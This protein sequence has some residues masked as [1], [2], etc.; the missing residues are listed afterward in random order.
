[1][2]RPQRLIS[3]LF[4]LGLSSSISLFAATHEITKWRNNRAGAV[5]VTFDDGY[6]SQPTIGKDLLSTRNLKGTFFLITDWLNWSE[7]TWELWQSVAA[8]GHEIGSHSVSHPYL[9]GLPELQLRQELS[10]SQ[11]VINLHIP[12]QFCLSFAYPY[13][14]SNDLVRAVTS[15]YY[16]A[17]RDVGGW[18]EGLNFYPGGRYSSINFYD[19][20][21]ITLDGRTLGQI[22]N[23][24]GSTIQ[25]NAWFVCIIHDLNNSE[26]IQLLSQF[27]DGLLVKDV[28]VDSFGTIVRYMRERLSSTFAVLSENDSEITLSLSHS[29]DN[30]IYN[31]PLTIRSAVPYS[32]SEVLITQGSSEYIVE[33]KIENGEQVVYY[34]AIPNGGMISLLPKNLSSSPRIS[35][36]PSSLSASTIV[37]SNAPTQTFSVWN[38][39]GG[40]L[41]YSISV[42][43]SW[44][45]C[46]PVSGTSTGEQDAITVNYSTASLSLGTYS[47]T[48]TISDPAAG[49][50]PQAI[51]VALTVVSI[52]QA[53][54]EL[55]FEEGSGT[56]AY[57]TS[58][59]NNNGT[60]YGG[61]VYTTDRAVGSYALSFDKIDDRVVCQ[62]NASLR[63]N[64][65]S[66]S[67]WVKHI[68]DTNASFGGIIQGPNG[69][70]FYYGYRILD[71]KNKPLA[72]INFGDTTG[73]AWILGAPFTLNEWCHLVMTY[74]HIKIRLYQDGQLVGEIAE[75]RDI[76]W[77]SVA[78][79]LTI[80]LAQWYF[81]G[82]IDKVMIFGSALTEQQ[83]Q[84]VYNER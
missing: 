54:M 1:M 38:S 28:W 51:P 30:S 48:I 17:G 20:K 82:M 36:S 23:I 59:N 69:D 49:N 18:P 25:N 21:S 81:K 12:S 14:D 55:N 32:W 64:D 13:G 11:A 2:K 24:V 74:D 31:I 3:I 73:P 50:S 45:S 68:T 58:S 56:T 26:K 7:V 72:Q 77:K 53:S 57:D 39:G 35:R 5:S 83:V 27:L 9:T 41:S 78:R 84:Q 10:Q 60:L 44:L 79:N 37:G 71:Y 80:G 4:F 62:S 63:P 8:E 6:L 67:L 15:E 52:P 46:S 33:P 42:D 43:Q 65:I 34:D 61:T 47:A 19:I 16:I 76:N 75:T 66:V 40:T 29:L 22:E 70:G